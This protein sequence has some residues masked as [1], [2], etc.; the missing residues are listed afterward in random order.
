MPQNPDL[1][2]DG[3]G[4]SGPPEPR[5]RLEQASFPN[6]GR[7]FFASKSAESAKSQE[8]HTPAATAQQQIS[9]ESQDA[10]T[11]QRGPG[12]WRPYP[13]TVAFPGAPAVD[14]SAPI[15]HCVPWCSALKLWMTQ[16]E[17][18]SKSMEWYAMPSTK[19]TPAPAA[20]CSMSQVPCG[21]SWP[22]AMILSCVPRAISAGV[23]LAS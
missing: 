16:P 1:A 20:T 23:R 6:H 2:H 3:F 8:A 11:R 4:L 12:A 14:W 10:H 18:R 7:N 22:M 19:A 17:G 13:A 5:R 9:V 15:L 21:E